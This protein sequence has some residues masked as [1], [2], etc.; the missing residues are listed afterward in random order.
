MLHHFLFHFKDEL[1]ITPNIVW[2]ERLYQHILD[3][4]TMIG[5][6]N[7][8]TCSFSSIYAMSMEYSFSLKS[9]PTY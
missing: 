5:V 3:T 4:T 1:R 8:N 9:E 6:L 7:N 2:L